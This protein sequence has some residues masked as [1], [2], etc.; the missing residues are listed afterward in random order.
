MSVCRRIA[1]VTLS[2]SDYASTKPVIQ[3]ALNDPEIEPIIIAGGS[4][5]LMRYGNSIEQIASDGIPI[6]HT[7]FFLAED[8]DSTEDLAAASARAA[9]EFTTLFSEINPDALFI[10]GDRW[11]MLAVASAASMLRIPI[12]HHSGG[13]ITQGSADN[14]VRYAISCLSHLHLTALPE[15]SDR[16]I[17]MG[18]EPWRVNSVGEPALSALSN[19]QDNGAAIYTHLGMK[20]G[21]V[22]SLATFHPTSFD[23]LPFDAQCELFIKVLSAID[24]P[25]IITAPNPDMQSKQFAESLKCFAQERHTK[26]S[27]HYVESLGVERYYSAMSAAAFMI[28]NS[29]SGLWEAPSFGLPVINMGERQ[30]G[31]MHGENVLNVPLDITAVK[32][33]IQTVQTNGFLTKANEV[34][35]PYVKETTILEILTHL[36]NKHLANRLIAKKFI[37]PLTQRGGHG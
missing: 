24:I 36:K 9:T 37:D 13:D 8:D 23:T 32:E 2:R 7:S 25:I 11:E 1:F 20:E 35:N 21:T 17:A 30:A 22:F 15:H 27:T 5:R 31:R 4:H 12:I 19:Y 34:E 10:V 29:S 26:I 6:H 14:Q 16:L 3:A 33:A 28:G 18:E